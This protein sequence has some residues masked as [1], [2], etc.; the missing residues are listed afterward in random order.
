MKSLTLSMFYISDIHIYY[1]FNV[2]IVFQPNF[3]N[4][5]LIH[6][7]ILKLTPFAAKH[8]MLK[9]CRSSAS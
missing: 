3:T 1:P 2:F 4:R 5:L 8:D 7:V 9:T 6:I